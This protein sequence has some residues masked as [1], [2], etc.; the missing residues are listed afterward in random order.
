[1]TIKNKLTFLTVSVLFVIAVFSIK[2]SYETWDSYNNFKETEALVNLSVKMSAVLHE[3]QKE[4][5]ASAGFLGSKGTKF[6]DILPKQHQSTD[7]KIK[8]LKRYIGANPSKY[9]SKMLQNIKLETIIP[10]RDKVKSQTTSVKETVKFYTSLNKQIIDTISYFSTIPKNGHLRTDFN[11]FVVFISA[12]ERAGIERAVLSNVFAKDFFTRATAAKFASLVSEQKAFINLFL[13]TAHNDMKQEYLKTKSDSSFMKV[14]AYRNIANAKEKG[15]GVNPTVWFKTI[16]KKINKLKEFE[17]ILAKHTIS[18]ANS[19]LSSS[20]IT[21]LLVLVFSVLSILFT[22][23]IAKGVSKGI[24]SSIDRFKGIIETITTKGDLSVVVDRRSVSRNEMDD[25]TRLLATLVSLIK[26]LTNRI[27]TSVHKASEGDFSYNLNDSGLYGDFAEAIHNVQDGINAMK[28]SHE[29]QR[30]INFTSNIR[31]VGN[32]GDGLSLIQ[33]EMSMLI[34]E[35]VD[36]QTKTK[37]TAQTSN[38]SMQEVESILQK[39]Q[40]LVEHISDS[41]VSIEGL[42]NQTNEITS[43]V[44]LIK[45]IAEQTNLL[46]LNAAIEA[47]R[48]GEH[49]RGFAVVAD[50]VRK[51]AERTQKATS[52]I[53]ISINSM[54]QEARVILDKS[55]TMTSLA[56]EVA[57]SVD[58]F[59]TTITSLNSDAMDMTEKINDM[60]NKVFIT[61]AKIDHIIYKA[62][63][64][65]DIVAGDTNK[66]STYTDCR[67]GKWYV[68]TGK[69][70]FG[71]TSAYKQVLEPHKQVHNSVIDSLNYI[72]NGDTRIQNEDK[73]IQNLKTMEENSA[74]LFSILNEM[75]VEYHK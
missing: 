35:L 31:S 50:E 41:N 64:Y 72:K 14:E 48:A 59:N 70:R 75:I 4:R 62:D 25:I 71:N 16:T 12:K 47:A 2:I 10:M 63:A 52:E 28:T 24:T 13:N 74:K 40:T 23:F 22:T 11:S 68:T 60:E 38:D 1:M 49:G 5:G 34:D 36:V 46:A 66:I 57:S 30:I 33:N 73:I 8:E 7:I 42:N 54:K 17:D 26:D 21:L 45:D 37:T 18:V 61:L 58:D 65:N 39:L 53:T 15:F 29:K 20:F 51:L 32:V 44:D 3:M 69:E 19:L 67:L 9:A 27:N 43:I 55:E 6:V 56:D